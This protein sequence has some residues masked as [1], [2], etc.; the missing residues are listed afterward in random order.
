MRT[1]HVR[2]DGA[3]GHPFVN[4][5]LLLIEGFIQCKNDQ[6]SLTLNCNDTIEQ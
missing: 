5:R 2:F 3:S 1:L 6:L 4:R